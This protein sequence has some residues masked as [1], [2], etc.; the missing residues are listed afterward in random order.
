MFWYKYLK[1]LL[2]FRKK[3]EVSSISDILSKSLLNQDIAKNL[4]QAY[5][6]Y[7]YRIEIKRINGISVVCARV[8]CSDAQNETSIKHWYAYQERLGSV[9][10]WCLD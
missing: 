7:S 1:F 2:R 5:K 9:A 3:S 10:S 8:R 6:D 4:S